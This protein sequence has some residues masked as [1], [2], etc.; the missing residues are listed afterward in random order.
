[1]TDLKPILSLTQDLIS[2]RSTDNRLDQIVKCLDL[3]QVSLKDT[4]LDIKRL[5]FEGHPALVATKNTKS[6]KIMLCGHI[7]I[8][9]GDDEQFKPR[10]DGDKLYGRG[11]LDMKSGVAVLVAAIKEA[12][13]KNQDVGLILTS[14]EESGGFH[15]TQAILEQGYSCQVAVLPDGGKAAHR[16]VQKAKGV[17]W[18]ELK[19]KGKGAHGSVPWQGENAIHKLIKAI[20]QVQALFASLEDHKHDHWTATCNLGQIQGGSHTNQVP[21]SATARC[22]IRFTEHESE[23]E[24][25]ERLKKSLPDGVMAEKVVTANMTFTPLDN[26]YV[27][28]FMQ[29]VRDQGREPEITVDYGSSDAR[30]FSERKIPVIICQPDGDGH[31]GKNEWV[32]IKGIQDYYETVIRFLDAMHARK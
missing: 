3:V 12:T 29:S 7:D 24:I 25:M 10:I 8:V 16:I 26:P 27:Q 5:D 17:L 4:G 19:A 22:D 1:M 31:H 2:C 21:E 23:N 15:G 11:A 28:L 9:E 30:F 32:S 14:D 18:V 20:D 13:T 6:P